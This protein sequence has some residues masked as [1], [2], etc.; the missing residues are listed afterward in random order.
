MV[1]TWLQLC[2]RYGME[3]GVEKCEAEIGKRY[4]KTL[5]DRPEDLAALSSSSLIRIS[6]AYARCGWDM[7]RGPSAGLGA[8]PSGRASID[9]AVAPS[10]K[11]YM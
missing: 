4:Q 7:A 3:E 6:Q 9:S 2:E 10:L 8:S 1:L 5:A 11:S